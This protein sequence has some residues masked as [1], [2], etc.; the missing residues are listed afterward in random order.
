MIA[1]LVSVIL[2]IMFQNS[3]CMIVEN[4]ELS[5]RITK[6]ARALLGWSGAVLSQEP[7]VPY[8]TIRAFEAGR[9][10]ILTTM[11]QQAIVNTIESAGI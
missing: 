2:H 1:F 5:A 9:T 6:A 3:L 8:D 4:M 10:K 11:N 7:G